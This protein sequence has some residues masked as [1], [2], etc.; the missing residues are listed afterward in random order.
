MVC[1]RVNLHVFTVSSVPRHRRAGVLFE[2]VLSVALFGGA[3]LFALSA[4]RNT[5]AS[6]ERMRL[7]QAAIDLA[8]SKMAELEAGLITVSDLRDSAGDDDLWT[9][10]AHTSRTEFTDLSLIELT[11]RQNVE[12]TEFHNPMSF[13]LRQL[14]ALRGAGE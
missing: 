9:F 11:V 3:A 12:E 1:G 5:L 8:K 7:Q 13:T 6:L 4:A 14:V 10:D 2:V